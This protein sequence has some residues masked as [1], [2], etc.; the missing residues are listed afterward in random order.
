MVYQLEV[1]DYSARDNYMIRNFYII[2]LLRAREVTTMK[3]DTFGVEMW[4][5]EWKQM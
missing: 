5:N 1:R 4:M 3:I 2:Q